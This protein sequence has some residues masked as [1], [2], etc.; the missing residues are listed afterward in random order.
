MP[1]VIVMCARDRFVEDFRSTLRYGGTVHVACLS[2]CSRE[3]GQGYIWWGF[4]SFFVVV[5]LAAVDRHFRRASSPVD[6]GPD[7]N[8]TCAKR[9]AGGQGGGASVT[10]VYQLWHDPHSDLKNNDTTCFVIT[11]DGADTD[12]AN[13]EKVTE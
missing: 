5:T 1:V 8:F 3:V 4:M 11:L 9:N 10:D 7:L 2:F 12:A 13:K 6:P